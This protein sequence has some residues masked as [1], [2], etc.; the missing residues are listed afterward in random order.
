MAQIVL[1]QA[2]AVAGSTLL[3]NGITVLGQ[4]IGG[5]AIG[6]AI[7]SVAGRAID[8]SLAPVTEGPRV[9]SL[10]ITESREGAGLPTVYGRMRVGGQV[11]WATKFKEKRTEQSAGKGGPKY[12][13]YSYSVSFA[14]A[15]CRG[16]ITRV[17][18]IWANGELVT[19]ADVNWRLYAGDEDQ[20]PDPLIEAIEGAGQAPAYRGAAYIV[21]EDLPLTPYGNRLPQL[22]FEV[23]RAGQTK[24]DTLRDCVRGVNIIPASGEFVYGTQIVRERRFPGIETAL[25]MNNGDGRSDFSVSLEQLQRDLPNVTSAALTVGWF[26]DSVQAGTCRIRPGVETRERETVPYGWSVDGTG[27]QSAHLI[28]LSSSGANYGGTPADTSVLEGMAALKQSGLSVTLSPFLLM[29]A[30]GFPWRGRITVSADKTALA[31]TQVEAFVGADGGFGFRHFIL[32]HARLAS[33][34]GGVEA[35]LIGSEMVGLTRI[36]DELGAFPF[37]EALIQ[38]AAEVKTILGPSTL[39]SYAADWTEYGAYVPDDGSGDV[40][41]PLDAL[42]ASPDIDFVGVD[43]YAP[44]GDWRDGE[45][46]LDFVA[47]FKT[48]DEDAYL[49]ANMAGGEAYDWYY[50]DPADRDAQIRS[51]IIDTAHGEAWIFR[52]KDLLGWW[53]AEHHERPGGTRLAVSTSWGAGL[54]PIRLIEIGY[55]AIDRG[56]NSPNLFYDPKSDESAFPPYSS[57]ARDDLFQRRALAAAH[58]FWGNQSSVDDILVWAWDARPWPHFPSRNDVWSD[59]DNWSYGH[60]LNGRSGLIELAEVVADL[61]EGDSA[62]TVNTESLEG[63][64]EGYAFDGVTSL[65]SSLSPLQA[66]YGLV[67]QENVAG[68]HFLHEGHGGL[69]LMSP[70]SFLLDSLTATQ[71]LLDKLPG[72]LIMTY[73]DGGGDYQPTVTEARSQLGDR[74]Y[75]IQINMPLVLARR[76][77]EEIASALLK[78]SEVSMNLE[79]ATGP[80]ALDLEP[81][82]RIDVGD[83]VS[84]QIGDISD[85][86]LRRDFQ[87][88]P[89]KN[90][91]GLSRSVRTLDPTSSVTVPAIPELVIIDGPPLTVPGTPAPWLAVSGDPWAASARI[92]AGPDD[93]ALTERAIASTPSSIG[94][95]LSPMSA[96]PLGRW[97]EASFLDVEL[98]GG[99]L[100]SLS[101]IA[102]LSGANRLLIETVSGWELLSFR[103]A[104]LIGADQWR[105]SGL[106]RGLNGSESSEAVTGAVVVLVDEN[107]VQA[108]FFESEVGLSLKWSVNEDTS[109]EFVYSN[110]SG[111]PWSV[112]H[113]Q[114]SEEAGGWNV[115]WVRRGADIS[116]SWALP[117]TDNTG[118]FMCHV[119]LAGELITTTEV[120]EPALFV[121]HGVDEIRVS[122]VGNDGRVGNWVS[123][124]LIAA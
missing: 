28:S 117:E 25:N 39:V 101:E 99:D 44:V 27:R 96:G 16:P 68:L 65:R 94:Q 83:G 90:V 62:I 100:S 47:G 74:N 45:T 63:F 61:F 106:L 60:W 11:I 55:P 17:D 43:W 104:E 84:W 7:G 82:D 118:I 57:G 30:P 98:V 79:V 85:Y 72:R 59:G 4:T 64:V 19:L 41:F 51:P 107:L 23:V 119:L 114:A 93:T 40:L 54:K 36:R 50:A 2:G 5:A 116:D 113:L 15:L 48:A 56:G 103:E 120:S 24:P 21:F 22:A 95:L 38:L 80:A 70:D 42:W 52:Q 73:I 3:P 49:Q 112:G 66:A 86:G 109:R 53:T 37:V 13:E 124:P 14:V 1:S 8:A 75:S 12:S 26:G 71:S 34:A 123:I 20:E 121:D 29:D 76:H 87:L 58:D 9:A 115:S 31:R 111:L 18:R 46:H 105:L 35:F 97:D 91:S 67:C 10:R 88:R 69:K 122:Q 108:K 6:Q 102:V 33:Q 77:A 89:E 110:T 32:H 78:Q 92:Y 81:G